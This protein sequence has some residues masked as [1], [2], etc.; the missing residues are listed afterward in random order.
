MLKTALAPALLCA[1][2]ITSADARPRHAT[3]QSCVETGSVMHRPAWGNRLY[4]A[5][6]PSAWRVVRPR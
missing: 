2:L 1:L 6:R 3:V 5:M 4:P